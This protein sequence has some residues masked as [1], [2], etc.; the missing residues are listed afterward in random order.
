MPSST[1]AAS[2]IIPAWNEERTIAS[3]VAALRALDPRLEVIVSDGG[4]TDGTVDA[5]RRAG[6]CVVA[7][8]R[9]RGVQLQHGAAEAHGDVLWF[10]HADTLPHARALTDIA[11]ALD[12]ASVVGGNFR[13]RFDGQ[14]TGARLLNSLQGIRQALGWHYGDNTIFV[15]R[16]A[17]RAVGG[18][19]DYP[20][21]ED[22]DLVKRL[23][24][25]GRFVT[26][27]G[28]VTTSSRRFD[29]GRFLATA[30]LWLALQ[31]LYWLGVPP[32]WL[33]RL[34]APARGGGPAPRE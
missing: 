24:R 6:A 29:N 14:S 13:L 25:A 9:G 31:A 20:L 30:L 15:R 28:P 2:A 17:Y 27:P 32:R 11:S 1:C 19:R 10:V 5:A 8:A 23:R 4:S 33:A 12:D 26:L 16:E 22:A 3:T 7:S 21:F 18:F 34:Y